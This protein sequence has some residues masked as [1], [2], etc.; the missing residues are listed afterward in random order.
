MCYDE[1]EHSNDG[2]ET[3]GGTLEASNPYADALMRTLPLEA[4][5]MATQQA[6]N[7][8]DEM[9]RMN[10]YNIDPAVWERL[11][12]SRLKKAWKE[13]ELKMSTHKLNEITAFLQVMSH[14]ACT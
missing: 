12:K 3:R 14:K 10:E 2:K 7:G 8:Y 4:E 13:M 6:L 9:S 11:Y 1:E 5:W